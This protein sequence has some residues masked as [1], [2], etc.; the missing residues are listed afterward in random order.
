MSTSSRKIVRASSAT[1]YEIAPV[2]A[3]GAPDRRRISFSELASAYEAAYQGRDPSRAQ[4]VRR[5]TQYLDGWIACDVDGDAVADALDDWAATP[6]RRFIG[7]D[8]N[9]AMLYRELGLPKPGSINKAKA[10]LSAVLG[11][12]K[13]RRLMPKGWTNPCREVPGLTMNNE[14]VRFL[15]DA[16]RKR[17]LAV[18]RLSTWNRLYLLVLMGITTGARKS[19]LLRLRYSDLDLDL[20]RATAYVRLSK[21]D[22]PRM[23]PLTPAVIEE[24]RRFGKPKVREALLFARVGDPDRA[25]TINRSWSTAVRD[26]HLTDFKFHD[27]RHTCAS[28]LAQNGASLLDVAATLGH[29]QLDVTRRYSHLTIDSKRAIVERVMGD[30]A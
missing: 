27:L 21:N 28:Y 5:W 13:T 16:E 17:L 22:E 3:I 24:I 29:K 12:A 2:R 7:K 4:I 20:D 11:F 6:V 1:A 10:V 25:F 9:G 8:D 30:I 14:R 15:D 18:C 26:A 23:L 19:E